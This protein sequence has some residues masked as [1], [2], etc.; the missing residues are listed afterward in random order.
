MKKADLTP[1][2]VAEMVRDFF[3]ENEFNL[4]TTRAEKYNRNLKWLQDRKIPTYPL[5]NHRRYGEVLSFDKLPEFLILY[6]PAFG[7]Y[8]QIITPKKRYHTST[9]NMNL[10]MWINPTI[11]MND[12][13]VRDTKTI[14]SDTGKYL[15]LWLGL[16]QNYDLTELILGK[17]TPFLNW[18]S[19]EPW[20]VK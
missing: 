13:Y 17:N 16:E 7:G 10:T 5:T 4:S 3:T 12:S 2:K 18:D 6:S 1:Q 9:A 11:W 14:D 19:F 15:Y 20:D 8:V